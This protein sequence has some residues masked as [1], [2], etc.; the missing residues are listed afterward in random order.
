MSF[1]L[2]QLTNLMVICDIPTANVGRLHREMTTKKTT[3]KPIKKTT[4]KPITKPINSITPE[5]FDLTDQQNWKKHLEEQGYA[6]I[7]NILDET[8]YETAF[9]LFKKD[10]N[11]VSPSFK[12]DD[13]ST[14]GIETAPIMFGKGMAT[15]NGFGQSDFM[16]NLRTN[17]KI[18]SIFKYIHSTDELVTSLDG[19]SVFISNKQKS[20]SWLHVD[21]NPVNTMYSIQGSY[22]FLKVDE[23]DA[24]FLIVP[25][26]HI[27]FKPTVSHKK[28]WILCPESEFL[29]KSKKLVIPKNCFT[30]WNSKLIHSNVGMT[31]KTTELN[32]LTAYIC[33]QPKENRSDA[34]LE[35]RID[36]YKN[37]KT[38]SHWANKCELKTYP[39]GFGKRYKERGFN[40]IKLKLNDDDAIPGERLALL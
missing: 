36:A 15:F 11:E 39:Y 32:R 22:N 31:K 20:K 18:Q 37:L 24:G 8:E 7:K 4:T 30:I 10:W 33:F 26:S 27:D 35:K 29:E 38:T 14:W 34:I 9:N 19:F 40:T 3:T 21:Q 28:D 23:N 13:K 1:T 17:S 16:W 25:K 6:V 5:L 12:F 2:E